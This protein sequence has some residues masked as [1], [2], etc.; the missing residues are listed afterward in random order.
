MPA[1]GTPLNEEKIKESSFSPPDPSPY[2][3]TPLNGEDERNEQQVLIPNQGNI[4]EAKD[5][6]KQQQRTKATPTI[7]VPNLSE[8]VRL[9]EL[10]T[11][12]RNEQAVTSFFSLAILILGLSYL[13]SSI[14]NG[15]IETGSTFFESLKEGEKND[16]E[17]EQ[18]PSFFVSTHFITPKLT[19]G[20]YVVA[21]NAAPQFKKDMKLDVELLP[22][23]VGK[24]IGILDEAQCL[25][26]IEVFPKRS[27]IFQ[28]QVNYVT[29][30]VYLSEF[31]N[32]ILFKIKFFF[33]DI[34]L[35]IQ[36][37]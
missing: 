30:F 18:K 10:E 6:T 37:F 11:Q 23:M 5:K 12:K 34:F 33:E 29:P 3:S 20:A 36:D 21:T 4:F 27:Y 24:I 15:L 1:P 19:L 7:L 17:D 9:S 14:L 22:F 8:T 35:E 32:S 2:P 31:K 16:E 26:L 28:S 25:I 13:S